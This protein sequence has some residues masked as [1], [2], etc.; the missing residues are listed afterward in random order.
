MRAR[1]KQ[2]TLPWGE[3]LVRLRVCWRRLLVR[4][5]LLLSTAPTCP[6]C[7][8]NISDTAS[9]CPKCGWQLTPE[10][11]L[12]AKEKQ[13]AQQR[14]VSIGCLAIVAIFVVLIVIGLFSK[15]DEPS[16]SARAA[17]ENSQWDRSVSQVKQWL[18]ENT[19]DPESL[20]FI[21]WSPVMKTGNGYTVRVKFRT[22]NGFGGYDEP[23]QRF[24]TL[25]Q[26][27]NVIDVRE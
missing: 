15:K 21:E 20:Q 4:G 3:S 6:E 12:A 14:N 24:F 7:N 10:K 13:A 27:G 18:N 11:V 8:T 1:F 9:S 22:K 5:V 16:N 19:R 25:D 17:V 23:E 26:A 2:H